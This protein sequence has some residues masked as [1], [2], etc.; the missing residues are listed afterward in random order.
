MQFH[1]IIRYQTTR[2]LFWSNEINIAYGNQRLIEDAIHVAEWQW[3]QQRLPENWRVLT[4]E[5]DSGKHFGNRN[6]YGVSARIR[7][8]EYIKLS[9]CSEVIGVRHKQVHPG[10]SKFQVTLGCSAKRSLFWKHRT[11]LD[12]Y[13]I[14]PAHCSPL[15]YIMQ[16]QRAAVCRYI[17]DHNIFSV[18]NKSL[19]VSY[20]CYICV[21]GRSTENINHGLGPR[22]WHEN[23]WEFYIF[24]AHFV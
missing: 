12:F 17:C 19:C 6:D 22:V 16:T 3:H 8:G 20:L 13:L 15:H 23:R 21:S 7:R 1:W 2:L 14:L 24:L 11:Y 4:T 18:Y 5:H 10:E 9:R